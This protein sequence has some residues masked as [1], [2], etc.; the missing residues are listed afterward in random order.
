MHY[1]NGPADVENSSGQAAADGATKTSYV[2]QVLY[3]TAWIFR[4]RV[5]EAWLFLRVLDDRKT[6]W[7]DSKVHATWRLGAHFCFRRRCRLRMLLVVVLVVAR[8]QIHT[9]LH[10]RIGKRGKRKARS[11]SVP[12]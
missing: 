1:L 7:A 5:C 11:R 12:T 10:P 3:R 4:G 9:N 8:S 6:R 2:G